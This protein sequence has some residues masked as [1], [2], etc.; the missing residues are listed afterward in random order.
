MR[1]HLQRLT[2]FQG[3]VPDGKSHMSC[4]VLRD[5]FFFSLFLFIIENM[6][7]GS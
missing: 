3:C 6:L 4:G 5:F 1:Y 7:L 2:M